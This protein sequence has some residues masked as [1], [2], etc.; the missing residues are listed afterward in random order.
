MSYSQDYYKK[1]K[2]KVDKK[3]KK[4]F[5][6]NPGKA[7][8][9]V[10]KSYKKHR[11]KRLKEAR[12]YRAKN[13]VALNAKSSK[14]H[15]RN[16]LVGRKCRYKTRYGITL[17]DYEKLLNRQKHRCVICG[18]TDVKAK[19]R[20]NKRLEVDHDHKSKKVRGL[21]CD[22]CNNGLGRFEDNPKLLRKAIKY[23]KDTK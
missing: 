9:Y 5:R 1:N 11:K 8:E 23:L 22:G 17:E 7:K 14:Y 16:P 10:A 12:L 21:L 19:I 3:N 15:K 18:L 2:D 20:Y 4:W 6:N 13:R